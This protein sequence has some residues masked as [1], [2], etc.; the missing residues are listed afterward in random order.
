MTKTYWQPQTDDDL[1][2]LNNTKNVIELL[3]KS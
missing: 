1:N 2:C 3:M